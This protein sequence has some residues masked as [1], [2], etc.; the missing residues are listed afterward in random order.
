MSN[1]ENPH[2]SLVQCANG[3]ERLKLNGDPAEVLTHCIVCGTVV[4]P[5]LAKYKSITC[6]KEHSKARHARLVRGDRSAKC[7]VCT[8]DLTPDRTARGAI[9]CC[10]EH[11]VLR[12]ASIRARVEQKRCKYCRKP[13]TPIE[14]AAFRRFRSIELMRPDFLYPAA[15]KKWQAKGGDLAGFIIALEASFQSKLGAGDESGGDFDLELVDRRH[16]AATGSVKSGRPISAPQRRWSRDGGMQWC[17]IEKGE[18]FPFD[19]RKAAQNAQKANPEGLRA[20]GFFPDVSEEYPLKEK[21]EVVHVGDEE[22]AA[23]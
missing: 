9:T 18:S 17:V 12:K 10:K 13:A 8:R 16:V 4:P 11:A 2:Y 3:G 21:P 22:G 15:F 23:A 6:S 7:V 1:V 5:E 20:A 14:R 19:T